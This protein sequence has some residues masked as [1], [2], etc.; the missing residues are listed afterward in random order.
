VSETPT[1]SRDRDRRQATV[2]FADIA[3]FTVLSQQM[4]PEDATDTMN[5]CFRIIERVVLE[6]GGAVDKFIGDCAM[7]LFGAPQALEEAPKIAINAAI[8]IR[9]AL[10]I[11]IEERGLN[12]RIDVHVAINSGLVVAG[13]VGGDVR[14]DYT[15]MGPTVNLAARLLNTATAGQIIVG[16]A[17][18]RYA[19]RDFEY[20]PTRP[21]KLKGIEGTTIGYEVLTREARPYRSLSATPS[22]GSGVKMV[23]RDKELAAI[24][25]LLVALNDGVGSVVSVLAES[26]LGKSRLLDEARRLPV[27][28]RATLLEGRSLSLGHAASFH[29]FVDLFA[30]WSAILPGSTPEHA[31]RVLSASVSAACDE[32]AREILPFVKTLMSIPLDRDDEI[33]SHG[34]TGEALEKLVRKSVR[35]LL[36]RIAERGPLVIVLEDVHWM[37]DSSLGLFESLL[38]MVD[39][40]PVVFMLAL[41]PDYETTSERILVFIDQHFATRHFCVR[42]DPLGLADCDLLIDGLVGTENLPLGIRTLIKD[43]AEGNPFYIEEVSRSLVEQEAAAREHGSPEISRSTAP[44]EVP[45]TIEAVIMSRVDRLDEASR[46]VLQV[47]AVVGRRFRRD[48]LESVARERGDVRERLDRLVAK[49][50]LVSGDEEGA[51]A[52]KH[53]L[54]QDAVHASL[55]NKTRRELHTRCAETFESVYRD[56]PHEGYSLLAYHWMQAERFDKAERYLFLAGEEAARAAA[57]AEALHYFR[58]AYRIYLLVHG[59]RADAKTKAVLEKNIGTALLNSG[60]LVECIEHLNNALRFHGEWVPRTTSTLT[61]KFLIDLP[62]V[63]AHIYA[64]QRERPKR[65][66]PHTHELCAIMYDRCRAQN[67][68]DPARNFFDNVASMRHL[69]RAD[70]ATVDHAAGMYAANGAFFAFAGLSF[71]VAQRFLQVA[72][73]VA[74][75]DKPLDR[76]QFLAMATIVDFHI[77]EWSGTRDIDAALL[78]QALRAGLLWDADTYLGFVCERDLRQG[79]YGRAQARMADLEQV[80]DAYGYGFARTNLSA[81]RAYLLL[82]QRSLPAARE[83]MHAY[84]A[85]R[86]EAPLRV[87]GLS[88]AA[89]VEVLDGKLEKA[90]EH[91]T[92]AEEIIKHSP[93]LPAFY[94]AAYANSRLCADLAALESGDA[95]RA[96][97]AWK[98]LK[99]AIATA[100]KIARDRPEAYRLAART[101]WVLGQPSKA[102]RWWQKALDE[103]THLGTRAEGA[104]IAADIGSS[105]RDDRGGF[106]TFRNRNADRWIEAATADFTALGLDWEIERLQR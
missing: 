105:L 72:E 87:F 53:A 94:G 73:R 71:R 44:V 1:I 12:G 68:T 41:R 84:Y 13:E 43:K 106:A 103:S 54:T 42:L 7:A 56:R 98:S 30:Q 51:Y 78:A 77:G 52:F 37:D 11:F 14:R 24:E 61:T 83:A 22:H 89:R 86:Y 29:P 63:L 33:V 50:F 20:R 59:E 34:I 10:A 91:L 27:A 57:S 35:R 9:N 76:F 31:A 3:G 58:E 90:E 62:V 45:G 6:H 17:T 46:Q 81:M 101:A 21:L 69:M 36:E 104:R 75:Q 82:E 39:T 60:K 19:S 79:H 25:S 85:D 32:E 80:V 66:R 48:I 92:R 2:L 97:R 16:K 93:H 102:R 8:E 26:G 28:E 74:R 99:R 23:G 38:P 65:E 67:P 49:H 18:H 70:P 40:H 47:A 64:G 88:G 4:D 15:V 95:S 96:R 55:L 5:G 100:R